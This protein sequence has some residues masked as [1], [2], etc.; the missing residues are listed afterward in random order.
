[1]ADEIIASYAAV[2][3][4]D[5]GAEVNSD[6]IAALVE[7][8]GNTVE[9]YWPVLIAGY[10]KGGVDAA[11]VAAAAGGGGGGGGGGGDGGGDAAADDAPAEE[12]EKSESE[13]DMGGGM[14]MFGGE[15]AGGGDY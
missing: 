15:P 8:T 4:H 2:A 6:Q 9:P 14:D 11:I 13:V 7:A 12:P 1:M 10:L 5:G 3:L